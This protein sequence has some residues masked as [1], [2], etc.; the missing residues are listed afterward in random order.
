MSK[1]NRAARGLTFVFGTALVLGIACGSILEANKD[2]VDSY[3]KTHSSTLVQKDGGKLFDAFTPDKEYLTEDG[4]GDSKKIVKAH[5]DLAKQ[6]Q[7]E[8]TVLLKNVN[9]A[10]P[11]PTT[12]TNKTKV[13]L[14]GVRSSSTIT[15]AFIG[16]KAAGN[17]QTIHFDEAFEQAGYEV[18]PVLNEAYEKYIKTKQ[19]GRIALLAENDFPY[20]GMY[21]KMAGITKF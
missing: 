11:C 16:H 3:F 4:K 17:N 8:G 20:M 12:T 9:N 7:A 2:A 18:N 5:E 15:G 6:I 21:G 10:L 13:S 14:F 19:T 1:L